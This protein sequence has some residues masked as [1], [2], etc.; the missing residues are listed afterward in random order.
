MNEHV[1]DRYVSLGQEAE[2]KRFDPD[3]KQALAWERLKQ[4]KALPQDLE[5][6]HH[7]LTEREYELRNNAGYEESHKF[8]Q[9]LFN[10]NPWD[11]RW[12]KRNFN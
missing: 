7:E 1:L 5:W 11:E 3:L 8:A 10:G 4:G 6:V 9:N 12:D 2:I